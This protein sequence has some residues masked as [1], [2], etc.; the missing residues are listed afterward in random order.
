MDLR[1]ET[2]DIIDSMIFD[3]F[4]REYNIAFQKLGLDMRKII[5]E[6]FSKRQKDHHMIEDETLDKMQHGKD[7]TL[8]KMQQ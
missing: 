2:S 6:E 8:D 5:T 3:E 7:E 1:Q 4:C